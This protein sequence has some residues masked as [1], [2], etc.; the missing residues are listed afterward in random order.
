MQDWRLPGQHLDE[1]NFFETSF[2][3][4]RLNRG[5]RRVVPQAFRMDGQSASVTRNRH[6]ACMGYNPLLIHATY[7]STHRHFLCHVTAPM[8]P[9]LGS[10][11]LHSRPKFPAFYSES[12]CM[13]PYFGISRLSDGHTQNASSRAPELSSKQPSVPVANLEGHVKD[14]Q[15]SIIGSYFAEIRS[16]EELQRRGLELLAPSDRPVPQPSPGR[17]SSDS[18][19]LHLL[20]A[21]PGR[22]SGA[23][24]GSLDVR[25]H[26]DP[27]FQTE[28]RPSLLGIGT[29]PDS[30]VK[31]KRGSSRKPEMRSMLWRSLFK[32]W[33]RKQC[34][35]KSI[36]G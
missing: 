10:L 16:R 5:T 22:P 15:R 25:C 33:N 14:A 28:R 1:A 7:C 20:P 19:Q 2:S 9:F 24:T 18:A 21:Q 17:S 29:L 6:P 32:R 13:A 8:D 27:P 31:G 26:D 36:R 30:L 11:S 23:T 3:L 34:C 35:Y 12:V 4:A